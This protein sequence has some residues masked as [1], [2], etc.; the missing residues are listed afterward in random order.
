M[1]D[2]DPGQ[3]EKTDIVGN[4][5]E[6][7]VSGW[8]IPANESIPVFNLKGSAGPAQASDHLAVEKSQVSNMFADKTRSPQVVIMVNQV[9]PQIALPWS[10][11]SQGKVT[12][13]IEGV[14][15]RGITEQRSLSK[16][17]SFEIVLRSQTRRKLDQFLLFQTQQ[18]ISGGTFLE[19]AIGLDPSPG[20]A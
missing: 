5:A 18:Q 2:V 13:G 1:F 4:E 12:I 20:F 6:M 9:I 19:L 8:G 14:S 10:H 15:Q 16:G 3:D 11:L 17:V 7:F